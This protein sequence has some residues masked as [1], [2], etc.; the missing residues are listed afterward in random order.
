[1]WIYYIQLCIY[2]IRSTVLGPF[3]LTE[4]GKAIT[5]SRF[6]S[7]I[8]SRLEAAGFPQNQCTGHSFRIGAATAAAQAGIAN[9]AIQM[10]GRWQSAAFLQYI[11]SPKDQLASFSATLLRVGNPTS[12]VTKCTT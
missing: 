5:K 4:E 1:M 12:A 9:S 3:F 7:V 6:V 10:L 8:R 11:R 2:Y